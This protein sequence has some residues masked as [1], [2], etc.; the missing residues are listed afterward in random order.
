MSIWPEA[1]ESQLKNQLGEAEASQLLAALSNDVPKSIRVNPLK[2]YKKPDLKRVPW[3]ENG[4]YVGKEYSF[5]LDPLIH[6]GVYYV[7]E[8]SSML[9]EQALKTAVDLSQPLRVLDLCA[10]PGGKSTHIASLLNQESIL[11][12][13]EVIKTRA[14]ILAENISKWGRGGEVIT[15]ADPKDF[16][17]MK[18]FFDVI[19]VDAPCSGEGMFRKDPQAAEEWSLANV[20]LC[21][22]R[23]QRILEDVWPALRAGG[24]L[25]YSTCT[26]NTAE[27]E[28]AIAAFIQEENATTIPL[29]QITEF[30]VAEFEYKGAYVYKC[31]PH[32]IAGEGFCISVLKKAGDERKA[33]PSKTKKTYFDY[34]SKVEK[35]SWEYLT[36]GMEGELLKHGNTLSL[37]PEGYHEII[38]HLAKHLR[39][40]QAGVKIGEIKGKDLIPDQAWAL[41]YEMNKGL[42]TQ[43]DL[44]LNDALL[45]LKKEIFDLP[46]IKDG[47]VL[48]TYRNVPIGFGKKVGNRL[49]NNYPTEWRIRMAI[50][51]AGDSLL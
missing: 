26:F 41:F 33:T 24:V 23:Q 10:A 44:S 20:S 40:V 17:R 31:F 47:L 32:K 14:N 6:A 18:S 37:I 42:Y 38:E 2:W 8:A 49:N 12:S 50:T 4:Y 45:F 29:T 28:E 30:G 9:L 1:F 21:A 46:D 36:E 15:S 13:N 43:A 11:V 16:T 25:I 27:N 5:T 48:F 22:G 7:Q 39:I 35:A 3:A 51:G 34:L 19:V